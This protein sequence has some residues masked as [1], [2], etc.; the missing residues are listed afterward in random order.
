MKTNDIKLPSNR[1]FGLFF[2]VVFI[3]IGIYF[4]KG[5]IDFKIFLFFMTSVLFFVT[6]IY[7][8]EKLTQLNKLWLK[9]GLL[10]GR[11][12]SL[13][14]LGII[15]FGIFT[16]ISLFTKIFKRDEKSLLKSNKLSS[17]KE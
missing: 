4:Y 6:A 17:C 13:I 12:T 16:P 15:F 14:I 10:L 8:P 7:K 11:I 1:K 9:I 2:S 3:I 5:K